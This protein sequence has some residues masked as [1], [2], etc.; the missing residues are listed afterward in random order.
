MTIFSVG[1]WL[2]NL[3]Q[4]EEKWKC[5]ICGYA[6]KSRFKRKHL[7]SYLHLQK[8]QEHNDEVEIDDEEVFNEEFLELQKT[9]KRK[10]DT[11]KIEQQTRIEMRIPSNQHVSQQFCDAV[12]K[13]VHSKYDE[14]ETFYNHSAFLA[15]GKQLVM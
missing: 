10:L 7:N 14:F 11:P 6:V 13:Y 15:C 5:E 2:V 8:A 4:M 9:K 1:D 12:E 3:V